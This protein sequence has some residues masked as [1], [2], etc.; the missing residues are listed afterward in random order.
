MKRIPKGFLA[1]AAC[2][3]LIAAAGGCKG[4]RSETK[5]PESAPAAATGGEE[6]T[7]E[8]AEPQASQPAAK[9]ETAVKQESKN[10]VII[11]ET[12]MGTIRV[13]LYPDKAPV[14]V[15][16]F[17]AYVDKGFYD[18][19]LFHRIVP[20]FVIQ[21]GG[22]EHGMKKKPTDPPIK[23]EAGNGLKNL[24][25]TLSMA[26]TAVVDSATSQFFIS[27]ADNDSLD[28]QDDTDPGF[29][30]A[31]FG[32]VIEGMDVVDAIAKVKTTTK[33]QYKDAPVKDVLIKTARLEP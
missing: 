16:N 14:S 28:H 13:E 25:G 9:E 4:G 21:G 23:N 12:S 26:R 18:G 31:V 27:L 7:A 24:R 29:G 8:P 19:T 15:A 10:P 5:E 30:Y 3:V 11:M 1:C 6:K 32:K 17:L 2:A 20:G 33:G 22:F